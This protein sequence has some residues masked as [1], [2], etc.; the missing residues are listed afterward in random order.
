MAHVQTQSKGK[1]EIRHGSEELFVETC[2]FI[3]RSE[4]S[5]MKTDQCKVMAMMMVVFAAA[6]AAAAG[7]LRK[8]DDNWTE[9]LSRMPTEVQTD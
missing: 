9:E 6:A 4:A 7:A 3:S 1:Y 5:A 8:W 2:V